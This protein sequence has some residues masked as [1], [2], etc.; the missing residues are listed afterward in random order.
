MSIVLCPS[1]SS[2]AI[3]MLNSIITI[4]TTAAV[5][6]HAILG[7][8]AHH[9]HSCESD[10]SLQAVVDH[11]ASGAQCGFGHHHHNDS[12]SP[13]QVDDKDCGHQHDNGQPHDC[14]KGDCSFSSVQRSNDLE[15]ML[16]FSV[17]CQALED[18]T[19]SDTCD[20]RLSPHSVADTP[21]GPFSK[22]GSAR[23]ITQVWRL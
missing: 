3:F 1:S 5:A 6:L 4:L 21:L 23:A 19:L 20:S 16:T 12:E 2:P 22:S 8:C 11:E 13:V 9:E 15:L 18:T 17:W 10:E 14:D 7:C